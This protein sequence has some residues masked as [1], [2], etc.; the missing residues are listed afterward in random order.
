M[1]QVNKRSISLKHILQKRGILRKNYRNN[2]QLVNG[3]YCF[4]TPFFTNL[5]WKSL[6]HFFPVMKMRF[7]AAS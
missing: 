7:V 2:C 1:I 3:E 5:T 4:Y 6:S